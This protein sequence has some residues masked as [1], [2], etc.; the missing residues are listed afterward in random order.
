M[1]EQESRR[2]ILL[3]M[4]GF[5]SGNGVMSAFL[6]TKTKT[7]SQTVLDFFNCK[8]LD[9]AMYL[10]AYCKYCGTSDG[11]KELQVCSGC[12]DM[13]YC[14]RYCQEKDWR[15]HK[16]TCR[17]VSKEL[18]QQGAKELYQQSR[19]A[20]ASMFFTA[21]KAMINEILTHHK[22]DEESKPFSQ[23]SI[24]NVPAGRTRTYFP[25][26]DAYV[27]VLP[28]GLEG[29]DVTIMTVCGECGEPAD[30]TCP[31][32]KDYIICSSKVCNKGSKHKVECRK[33]H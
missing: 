31:Y 1:A 14:S 6:A 29:P 7:P 11:D 22:P 12:K 30:T 9:K 15:C 19:K 17:S 8:R 21:S 18:R 27:D 13:Y 5:D 32:C 23:T 10:A 3:S 28:A 20:Q 24:A 16:P 26:E 2:K 4:K 25:G 33:N